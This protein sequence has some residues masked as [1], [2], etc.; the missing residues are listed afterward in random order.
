M[1]GVLA[2]QKILEHKY[3]EYVLQELDKFKDRTGKEL[4]Y[5]D[6]SHLMGWEQAA[7][8]NINP[9]REPKLPEWERPLKE[10]DVLETEMVIKADSRRMEKGLPLDFDMAMVIFYYQKKVYVQFFGFNYWWQDT[11]KELRNAQKIK[12]WHYQNQTDKPDNVSDE[13]WNKR[14]NVWE[15][16][17]KEHGSEVPAHCGFS[18]DFIDRL[19]HI[20]MRWHNLLYRGNLDAWE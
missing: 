16:I 7:L 1:D 17:F 4:I 18:V 5:K 6:G 3:E 10:M 20:I 2:I 8:R 15:G 19:Q 12:D 9:Y 14:E 11:F 13:L